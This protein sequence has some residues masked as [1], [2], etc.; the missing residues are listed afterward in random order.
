[1]KRVFSIAVVGEGEREREEMFKALERGEWQIS[2]FPSPSDLPTREQRDLL[3]P[4][5]F[6]LTSEY[7]WFEL[8]EGEKSRFS[9][10]LLW[11]IPEERWEELGSYLESYFSESKN[12]REGEEVQEIIP[13]VIISNRAGEWEIFSRIVNYFYQRDLS[14]LQK[15]GV[16][17]D[18]EG[19]PVW[20]LLPGTDWVTGL[21]NRARFIQEM[22]YQISYSKR[23]NRPFSCL[24]VKIDNYNNL[25]KE[26]TRENFELFLEEIAGWMELNI[27]EADLIA[28]L[29]R[30]L[31][32][33]ILPET[34]KKEA[35]IV[36]ERLLEKLRELCRAPDKPRAVFS[37]GISQFCGTGS[38]EELIEIALL[39]SINQSRKADKPK[40]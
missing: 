5:L 14:I 28:R 27:R 13:P 3:D 1:M 11:F 36:R 34:E 26:T 22:R 39:D 33:F 40:E 9:S 21:H 25:V 15:L 38:P 7:N 35:E 32:G 30:D 24:V 2:Q 29:N 4:D 18:S 31:F 20:D 17:R 8:S 6:I 19:H 10:H 23:Y 16:P 12:A 37:A